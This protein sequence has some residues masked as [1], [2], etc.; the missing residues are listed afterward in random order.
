MREI[1]YILKGANSGIKFK[2][3][4]GSA[5]FLMKNK[6]ASYFPREI[7]MIFIVRDRHFNWI[8]FYHRFYNITK[9]Y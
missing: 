4:A 1:L 9:V 6:I 5:I 3:K 2:T 8:K 7:D